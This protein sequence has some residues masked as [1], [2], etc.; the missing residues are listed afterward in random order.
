MN[1][2]RSENN[3]EK[4]IIIQAKRQALAVPHNINIKKFEPNDV[5]IT[6]S[7]TVPFFKYPILTATYKHSGD[8]GDLIYSLPVIRETGGG[9]LYLNLQNLGKKPDGTRSGFDENIFNFIRP[10]L[11]FQVY[12]KKVEIWNG[13]TID[14]DLDLFRKINLPTLNLCEKILKSYNVPT[15]NMNS[16]WIFCK[17]NKIASAVFARSHRYRNQNIDYKP[18]LEKHKN[19]CVFIGLINEYED[20]KMRFGHLRYYPVKNMLDMAETINGSDMFY[21]NQSSP[22]SLALGLGKQI[23]QEIYMHHPDCKFDRKNCYYI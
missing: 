15:D 23:T 13:Q 11:E 10:L 20:F 22:M 2:R 9:I 14:L 4:N 21:G 17:K 16:P 5:K 8:I 12:I 18:Y 6:T 1:Y 19:D 7:N 3:K